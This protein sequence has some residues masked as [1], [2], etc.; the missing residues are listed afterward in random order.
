MEPILDNGIPSGR[1]P[2]FAAGSAAATSFSN[3]FSYHLV[4]AGLTVS[5]CTS[6]A[7]SD[8]RPRRNLRHTD[9]VQLIKDLA[10]RLIRERRVF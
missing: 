10:L 5:R 8:R 3:A 4:A 6:Q 2:I 9:Q 7:R 1:G